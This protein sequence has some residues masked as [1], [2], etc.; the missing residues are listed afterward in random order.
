MPTAREIDSPL[1][2]SLLDEAL[3]TTRRL[4]RLLNKAFPKVT[5]TIMSRIRYAV[6]SIDVRWQDGPTISQ[7]QGICDVL[8]RFLTIERA[9]D[10]RRFIPQTII[11]MRGISPAYKKRLWAEFNALASPDR[12][13]RIHAIAKE[14]KGSKKTAPPWDELTELDRTKL[15]A[16][17]TSPNATHPNTTRASRRRRQIPRR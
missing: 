2:A 9:T 8:R 13:E 7:V 12:A 3:Q 10:S 6:G 17:Y 11:A 14:F 5:F 1:T 16:E 15:L 4:R